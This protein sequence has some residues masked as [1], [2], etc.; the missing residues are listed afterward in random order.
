MPARRDTD[1][2][3]GLPIPPPIQSALAGALLAAASAL[4]TFR[5]TTASTDAAHAQQLRDGE[6]AMDRMMRLRDREFDSITETIRGINARLLSLE[7]TR[8]R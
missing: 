5:V 3:F 7:A 2:L 6:I 1:R 4:I 8:C